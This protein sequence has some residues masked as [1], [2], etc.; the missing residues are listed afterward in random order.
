MV[1]PA[2]LLIPICIAYVWLI[3]NSVRIDYTEKR[4]DAVVNRINSLQSVVYKL[5][6]INGG[7]SKKPAEGDSV[8]HGDSGAHSSV[9]D[10]ADVVM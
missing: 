2:F 9:D 7:P 8:E 1:R 5:E 10:A 6:A 3:L 4:L